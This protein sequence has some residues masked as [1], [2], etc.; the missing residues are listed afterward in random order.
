MAGAIDTP[1]MMRS[2]YYNIRGLD[3]KVTTMCAGDD[4]HFATRDICHG[5]GWKTI[6][7]TLG[8]YTD[9]ANRFIHGGQ[10]Y[11]DF[12]GVK[13]LFNSRAGGDAFKKWVTL[14]LMPQLEAELAE[15]GEE[16]QGQPQEDAE[17]LTTGQLQD[18]NM[19]PLQVQLVA[20][21][22]AHSWA[23]TKL[24]ETQQLSESMRCAQLFLE[25]SRSCGEGE[26]PD[27]RAKRKADVA[28]VLRG[29]LQKFQEQLA[30]NPTEDD[31][32][33]LTVEQI[34]AQKGLAQG[35]VMI[36]NPIFGTDLKGAYIGLHRRKPRGIPSNYGHDICIY[37]K[38]EDLSLIH[39]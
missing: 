14:T 35:A 18:G 4:V 16:P 31:E 9:E 24:A 27:A 22:T 3:Y 2:H 13:A 20:S 32:M 8:T 11:L 12:D 5:M 15:N 38:F 6:P 34:L 28:V 7:T 26:P 23:Q 33:Y 19:H 10:P 25:L 30:G 36:F 17:D 29:S 1:V 21:Q 39:I 37:H